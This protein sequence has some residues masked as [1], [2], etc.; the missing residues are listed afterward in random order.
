M[1]LS[2]FVVFAKKSAAAQPAMAQMSLPPAFMPRARQR[3][4][5]VPLPQNGS[6]TLPRNFSFSSSA[7]TA[8]DGSR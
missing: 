8:H 3:A 7:S 5:M 4:G 2:C 6:N 1:M